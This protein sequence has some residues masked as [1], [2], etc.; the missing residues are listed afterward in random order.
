RKSYI[1]VQDCIDA[2]LHT[3]DR[4]TDKV[5]ILNLGT[6]EYVEVNDSIQAI[7]GHLGLS[8]TFTYSGGERGWI[9]DSPFIFLDTARVRAL[10]W[11]PKL[12]IRQAVVRTVQY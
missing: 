7:V 8:P 6:D 4:A 12:T 10:G 5:T 11:Q 1:Y 2:I 3:V 9:G